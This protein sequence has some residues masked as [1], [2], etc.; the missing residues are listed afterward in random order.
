MKRTLGAALSLMLTLAVVAY[1]AVEMDWQGVAAMLA[2]ARW[3]WLILAWL[4]YLLNYWLR[5]WRMRL[6]LPEE[7]LSFRRLWTVNSLYGMFNYLL[8]AKSGELVLLGLLNRRLRISLPRST[9]TVA[10][11]RFF[12]FVVVVFFMPLI[13]AGLWSQLPGN[14]IFSAILFCTLTL[15]ATAAVALWL[16]QGEGG[17]AIAAASES[18]PAGFWRRARRGLAQIRA[19]VVEISRGGNL[20][21]LTWLT[22]GIWV[23]ITLNYY[24]IILSLGLQTSLPLVMAVSVLMVPATLLPVQGVANLGAH[25]LG[26]V[27]AFMLFGYTYDY[28]LQIAVGSHTILLVFVLA[29]GG[30]GALAGW[31]ERYPSD[32]EAE[33]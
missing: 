10:A 18:R 9:V 15:L 19:G 22:A 27:S 29:L 11:A 26:W 14:I 20:L 6:L 32:G 33:V 2:A 24:L 21:R 12:D 28:S 25:E 5:V 31:S 13:V 17:E 4:V 16:R 8:P 23:C 1:A 7:G 30:L 3:P